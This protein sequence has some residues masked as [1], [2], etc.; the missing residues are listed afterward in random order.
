MRRRLW[1][2]AMSAIIFIAAG[3]P[4]AASAGMMCLMNGS[5]CYS[6]SECCS[7]RCDVD[8][9]IDPVGQCVP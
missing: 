3:A 8:S 1:F 4:N 2:L 5:T 6:P 9:P 7:N